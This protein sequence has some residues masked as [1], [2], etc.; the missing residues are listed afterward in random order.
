MSS[1]SSHSKTALPAS[2]L[3]A[4]PAFNVKI[5]PTSTAVTSPAPPKVSSTIAPPSIAVAASV[6]TLSTASTSVSVPSAAPVVPSTTQSTVLTVT[7]VTID[8]SAH[9]SLTSVVLSASSGTRAAKPRRKAE[10]HS[11]GTQPKRADREESSAV[12][13]NVLDSFGETHVTVPTTEKPAAA[14]TTVS[15]IPNLLTAAVNELMRVRAARVAKFADAGSRSTTPPSNPLRISDSP[16]A[17]ENPAA[18]SSESE[19]PTRAPTPTCRRKFCRYRSQR[20]LRLHRPPRPVRKIRFPTLRTSLTLLRSRRLATRRSIS[21]R[22]LECPL[23][24]R[25]RLSRSVA[26]TRRV[27]RGRCLRLVTRL[28]NCRLSSLYR[29]T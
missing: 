27:R 9:A 7:P 10:P 16:A 2:S 26:G 24:R 13:P 28:R 1:D 14:S 29:A 8:Q 4:Q 19:G 21:G 23:S 6:A 17:A 20:V 11:R 22:K 15:S 18:S 25:N 12:A 5:T 3:F